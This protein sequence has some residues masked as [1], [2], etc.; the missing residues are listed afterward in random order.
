MAKNKNEEINPKIEQDNAAQSAASGAE[1]EI[2]VYDTA[3]ETEASGAP[4]KQTESGE[5][6]SD[7]TAEKQ[8]GKPEKGKAPK[9]AKNKKARLLVALIVVALLAATVYAVLNLR[10]F[11]D[12]TAVNENW[13][14][15]S[16][17]RDKTVNILVCG[18]DYDVNDEEHQEMMT[19]VIMVVN[20]DKE[21]DKATILQIPRDTY[22]GE[23][24]VYT[25][26]INALYNWGNLPA[27]YWDDIPEGTSFGKLPVPD[28]FGNISALMETINNQ[29]KL[30]IDHYVTISMEGFRKAID[31]LGG[32]EITL[33]E[34]LILQGDGPIQNESGELVDEIVLEPGTHTLNGELADLFVRNRKTYAQQDIK[35]VAVQRYFFAALMNKATSLS[36]SELVSLAN[37]IYPY[38]ETDFSIQELL[39]LAMEAK[40][41]SGD[42]VTAVRIPVEYIQGYGKF[43]LDVLTVHRADL[44]D[45]L[46]EYMRPYSDPVPETELE[47]IEIQNEDNSLN[48]D[49]ATLGEYGA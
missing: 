2:R 37:A 19:D 43:G 47:V 21:A 13:Q 38:L 41:L 18:V 1:T 32:I 48:D 25:G 35:R 46:N 11:S 5:T 44:A 39:S 8:S 27:D 42:S 40:N 22:V 7:E 12:G 30:P 6:A 20:L 10:L 49:G 45:M 24:V 29:F 14:T 28:T 15:P 33:E 34:E 16:Y 17:L 31:M 36:T 4:A 9:K 23:D 26:K 3:P